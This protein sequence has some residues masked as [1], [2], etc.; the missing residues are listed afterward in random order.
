MAKLSSI[1]KNLNR[2]RLVKTKDK[3]RSL[4][5]NIF[6]RKDLSFEERIRIMGKLSEMPRNSFKT[7]IR[8]RCGLTGRSR[9]YYR[10]FNLSRI[11]IRDYGSFGLIPGLIK[12]SW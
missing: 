2:K 7:R 1:N 3:T 8:N 10:K 5:K 4:L 11:A 6:S 9:G 12:S